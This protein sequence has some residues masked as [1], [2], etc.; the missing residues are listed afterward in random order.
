MI[1]SFKRILPKRLNLPRLLRTK[2]GGTKKAETPSHQ[3]QQEQAYEDSGA[4]KDTAVQRYW[5]EAAF[6]EDNPAAQLA[7]ESGKYQTG[8]QYWRAQLKREETKLR[9]PP[10]WPERGYL[11]MHT[12]VAAAVAAKQVESGYHHFMLYG[13]EEGRQQPYRMQKHH[14][15]DYPLSDDEIGEIA[16]RWQEHL[17]L[18]KHADVQQAVDEGHYSTGLDHWIHQGISEQRTLG[19]LYWHDPSYLEIHPDVAKAIEAG[20][21][22]D[23]YEHYRRHGAEEGRRVPVCP[24]PRWVTDEMRDLAEIEPLL[25]P[26]QSFFAGCSF[27][28]ATKERT[29]GAN[30]VA[31]FQAVGHRQF[32]HVFVL[33]WLSRGG[34]DAGALHHIGTLAKEFDAQILVI[35]TEAEPSPWLERL[36]PNVAYI[37]FSQFFD[38]KEDQEDQAKVALTRILLHVGA[39]VVHNIN[40]SLMWKTTV[41]HGR[42]LQHSSKLYASLF[43]FG[44]TDTGAPHGYPFFLDRSWRHLTKVFTDHQAFADHLKQLYGLPASFCEPVRFPVLCKKRFSPIKDLPKGPQRVLWASRIA[45]EKRPDLLAQIAQ[46]MPDVVFDVYGEVKKDEPGV[47]AEFLQTLQELPNVV[48]KGAFNGFDSLPTQPYHAL[49]YTTFCD[50][51]PN[52]LLEAISSGLLVV[53][54]DVG[55]IGELMHPGSPVFVQN[56]ND[57]DAFVAALRWAFA[58]PGDATKA[59][60]TQSA[61]VAAKHSQSAFKQTLAGLESYA[62]IPQIKVA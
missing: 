7:I 47:T 20:M 17:Y 57:V 25:F 58:N 31:L 14:A 4:H 62:S 13:A 46:Q 16:D 34:A 27:Y 44:Y 29:A 41:S 42:A 26:S 35:T 24:G 40:S 3:P 60:T 39:P 6:L 52:I 23:G 45:Q 53:A 28:D 5:N 33:P 59:Q 48:L 9:A 21:F 22:V 49:L 15:P 55:G 61:C 32:T 38:G 10:S 50:G 2:L 54:P 51:L 1:E 30:L 43:A 36:P 12:D 8:M 18:Q 11:A 19:E 37:D 56:K